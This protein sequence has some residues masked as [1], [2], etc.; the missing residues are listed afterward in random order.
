[1]I[2]RKDMIFEQDIRVEVVTRRQDR[3]GGECLVVPPDRWR[4]PPGR[5]AGGAPGR[6]DGG[7]LG[8]WRDE[9]GRGHRGYRAY[10]HVSGAAAGAGR[11]RGDRHEPRNAGSVPR[12]PAVGVRY[13]GDGG[14]RRGGRG[15]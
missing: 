10:R 7:A 13:Q 9:S 2:T 4:V 15:R 5:V 3:G 6:G 14:P 1:M 8:G 11:S 12:E